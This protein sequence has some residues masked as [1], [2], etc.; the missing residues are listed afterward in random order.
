MNFN[1]AEVLAYTNQNNFLEGGDFQYGS[2]KLLSIQSVIDTRV[3]NSDSSGVKETQQSLMELVS[4]AHD[5]EKIVINGVDFGYGRIISI[6]SE[7]G[8]SFDLNSIRLGKNT[9][10]IQM[11]DSGDNDL[12]NMTG[13]YLT[14]LKEKFSKHHLLE[15]F[16]ESFS[17]DFSLE[18]DYS[19]T[20]NVSAK[21]F[22]GAEV[23]DP[24]S[25]AR[26]L[27]SGIFEQDPSL[28]FLTSQ[29]SGFYNLDGKKYYNEAYNL[30]TNE[31][32]FTKNFQ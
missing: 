31:Y 11:S 30:Q 13:N 10:E 4:G 3:S 29:R 23:T 21:Y 25:E 32:S 18:N 15:S 5:F 16:S 2:T 20:H 7:T 24:I 8:P 19:Y 26:T 27:A 28:G 12:Y 22:S 14:G 9:F 6:N 1:E 17:F